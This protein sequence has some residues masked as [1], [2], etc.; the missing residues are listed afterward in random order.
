[1]GFGPLKRGILI[2]FRIRGGVIV[3]YARHKVLRESF[4]FHN[5]D[6]LHFN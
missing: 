6:I 4:V 5:E 3:H 1:V 2:V